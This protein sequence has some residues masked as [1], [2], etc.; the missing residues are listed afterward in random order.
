[1]KITVWIRP[2]ANERD[3]TLRLDTKYEDRDTP[4]IQCYGRKLAD[5]IKGTAG[6]K[7]GQDRKE[8]PYE[9][10][11]TIYDAERKIHICCRNNSRQADWTAMCMAV[12]LVRR[13]RSHCACDK[14]T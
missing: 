10:Q 6:E 2:G 14:R 9:Y 5:A 3:I 1:M 11:R 8:P 12:V 7:D 4:L 13:R